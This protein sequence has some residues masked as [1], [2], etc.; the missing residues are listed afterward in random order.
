VTHG[1][2]PP[3]HCRAAFLHDCVSD[4]RTR[5]RQLGSD[6]LVRWGSPDRELRSLAQLMGASSVFCHAGA[7]AEE[8]QLQ[9]RVRD[10]LH[11]Q[12]AELRTWWGG[13]LH[14]QEQLPFQVSPAGMPPSFTAFKAALAQCSVPQAL[15]A[16]NRVRRLPPA[17]PPCGDIP[18]LDQLCPSAPQQPQQGQQ[19][20]TPVRGGET[21][22]LRLLASL[23]SGSSGSRTH[24]VASLAPWLA[25]G[26]LSP[27]NVH[28]DLRRAQPTEAAAA[29]GAGKGQDAGSGTQWVVFEL[30][31]HDFFRLLNA[32]RA[33]G[34]SGKG[35]VPSQTRM[36]VSSVCA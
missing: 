16:P 15:P 5:L 36:T 33:Q 10:A 12:G 32:S 23:V 4:L 34:R 1:N 30:L 29:G 35:C 8:V 3:P 31:W 28:H 25:M 24:T 20:R 18:T 17:C 27:R 7:D 14:G 19:T 22:A 9:E 2:P 6:L 11:A 21:E 26:C 13:T